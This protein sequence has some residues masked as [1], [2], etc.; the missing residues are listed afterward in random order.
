MPRL[1]EESQVVP[2]VD[3]IISLAGKTRSLL[4]RFPALTLPKD[5][6]VYQILLFCDQNKE[7]RDSAM[8]TLQV[9]CGLPGASAEERGSLG[10][11]LYFLFQLRE[12]LTGWIAEADF[13]IG[14]GIVTTTIPAEPVATPSVLGEIYSPWPYLPFADDPVSD[15]DGICHIS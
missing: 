5:H 3:E 13:A 15:P 7:K 14:S 1:N 8:N 4:R 2:T 10:G 11:Q 12:V 6:L 9:A